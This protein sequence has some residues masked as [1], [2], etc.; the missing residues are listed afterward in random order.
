VTRLTTSDGI[1]RAFLAAKTVIVHGHRTKEKKPSDA[2]DHV[3]SIVPRLQ[4]PRLVRLPSNS[5]GEADM[6]GGVLRANSGRE[7]L[8][9]SRIKFWMRDIV[10]AA[11]ANW[12]SSRLQQRLGDHPGGVDA[13]LCRRTDRS[14]FQV[15]PS[16]SPSPQA[17][18]GRFLGEQ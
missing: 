14:V 9:Q 4:Y 17:R 15:S 13:Q 7:Q 12:L 10:A 16:A 3:A 6:A 5:A 8:Q 2:N 1:P 18:A 11:Y